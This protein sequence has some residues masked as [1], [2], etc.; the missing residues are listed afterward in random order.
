MILEEIKILLGRMRGG[1]QIPSPRP[2]IAQRRRCR[3]KVLKLKRESC[4]RAVE[5]RSG[6]LLK[7]S[8]PQGGGE[9]QNE[10]GLT[11]KSRSKRYIACSDMAER[12]GFEPLNGFIR[13]TISNRAPST[14]SATSPD[15]A[16]YGQRGNGIIITAFLAESRLFLNFGDLQKIISETP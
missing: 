7:Q 10:R 13:Y 3:S 9:Q 11:I 12:K 1:A 15:G 16:V 14:S 4:P 6:S 5:S 2:R 8:Q